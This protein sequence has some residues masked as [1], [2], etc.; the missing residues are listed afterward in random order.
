[1]GKLSK[2]VITVTGKLLLEV[3]RACEITKGNFYE[4]VN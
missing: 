3:I 4:L 1:M 2:Q